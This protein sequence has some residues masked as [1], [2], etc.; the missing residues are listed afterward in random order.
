M[1]DFT[2]VVDWLVKNKK[3]SETQL[4]FV[5]AMNSQI[6]IIDNETMAQRVGKNNTAEMEKVDGRGTPVDGKIEPKQLYFGHTVIMPEEISAAN[7]MLLPSLVAAYFLFSEGA[8]TETIL[9]ALGPMLHCPFSFALHMHRALVDDPVTR[10]KIF[11][12]DA[13]FI[14]LHAFLT[15]YSWFL[16]LNYYELIYHIACVLHIFNSK[17]LEFP[18]QKNTIDILCG[19]GVVKSSFG[20]IYHDGKLW[21]IAMLFWIIGFS[22]HNKKLF[23]V[24]SSVVFHTILAI[25]QFCIMAGCQWH[26]ATSTLGGVAWM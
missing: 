25:P 7:S 17:P 8:K 3:I 24:H 5:L 16:Q 15:G 11:K 13:S 1:K 2:T 6:L 22:I 23:G 18:K 4:L 26:A 12:F 9:A 10:T 20:L 14:H 21:S 19:L